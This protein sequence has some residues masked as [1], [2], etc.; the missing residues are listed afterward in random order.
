V[1]FQEFT[2][3]GVTLKSVQD[4]EYKRPLQFFFEPVFMLVCVSIINRYKNRSLGWWRMCICILSVAP[5]DSVI[6]TNS[7]GKEEAL[8]RLFNAR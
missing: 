5:I 8:Q 7:E 3:F 6:F 4:R 1:L 2:R